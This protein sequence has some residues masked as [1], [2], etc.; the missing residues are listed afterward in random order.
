MRFIKECLVVK[1]QHIREALRQ[2]ILDP[3]RIERIK[4]SRVV[5]TSIV[6]LWCCPGKIEQRALARVGKKVLII[7]F[8]GIRRAV[9]CNGH[10]Q[11]GEVLIEG[12]RLD[13]HMDAGIGRLEPPAN[14]IEI[15]QMGGGRGERHEGDR[16]AIATLLA[17]AARSQAGQREAENGE[18]KCDS[19]EHE[20]SSFPI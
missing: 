2:T 3:I 19:F 15:L 11:L 20:E 17:R 18:Y 7:E 6:C 1:E 13:L 4:R 14:R 8:K 12:H 16:G 9:A 5:D 10:L